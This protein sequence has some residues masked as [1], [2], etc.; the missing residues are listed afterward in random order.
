MH[1]TRDRYV[2]PQN[3]INTAT[4]HAATSQH[5]WQH[6]GYE[7]FI[8]TQALLT[9]DDPSTLAVHLSIPSVRQQLQKLRCRANKFTLRNAPAL[10]SDVPTRFSRKLHIPKCH[11]GSILDL[12]RTRR[13]CLH[14][15]RPAAAGRS[16]HCDDLCNM[17]ATCLGSTD[18]RS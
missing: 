16:A 12:L 13:P 17:I 10:S 6:R 1:L 5:H 14:S 9:R 4:L 18:Q 3:A 8:A 15:G 2:Y 7:T 11:R